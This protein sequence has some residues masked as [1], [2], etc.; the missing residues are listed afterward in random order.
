MNHEGH[1]A[2]EEIPLDAPPSCDFVS[3]VVKDFERVKN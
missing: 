1:E 2:D 3:L